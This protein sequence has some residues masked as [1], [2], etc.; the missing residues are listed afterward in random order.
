MMRRAFPKIAAATIAGWGAGAL[1]AMF[2]PALA[3]G[4]PDGKGKELVRGLCQSCHDLSPITGSG[5]FSRRDWEM[6]VMSMIDMGAAIKPEE[7]PVIVNYLA[8][9]FPP[10]TTK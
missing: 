6:V 9:S 1:A 8:A 5:G 2:A 7:V 10:K 4:L 3:Q